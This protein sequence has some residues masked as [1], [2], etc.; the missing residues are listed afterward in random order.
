M[1]FIEKNFLVFILILSTL[2]FL[3][4]QIFTPFLSFLTYLLAI[5]MLFMGITLQEQEI[6]SA[7]K[8]WKFALL[9]TILQFLIMPSLA[10]IIGK[11]FQL[12]LEFQLGI[13]LVGVCPGGTASNVIVYLFRGNVSLSILMTTLSTILSVIVT[14]YLLEF[15][16]GSQIDLPT[17]KMIQDIFLVVFIPLCVGFVGKRYLKPKQVTFLQNSASPIAIIVIS[18]IIA[19][20]VAVNIENLKEI[21]Y[22]LILAIM[23]HNLFGL[24]FGYFITRIFTSDKIICRTISIEVGMQNSGLG[25]VLANLHFSKMAAIPAAFFSFWHNISGIIAAKNW[26]KKA[27]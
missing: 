18:I 19:T 9:G 20:I 6:I 12:P 4:P 15:Y 13:L 23:I 10:F 2:A 7:L 27:L 11:M 21:P 16:I 3:I 17:T 25:V 22:K 8:N 24:I 1:K 26:V 14:P 5:V